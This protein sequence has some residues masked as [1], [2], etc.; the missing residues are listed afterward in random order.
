MKAY[1]K[2]NLSLDILKRRDDGYHEILM[3]MQSVELHD[4]LTIKLQNQGIKL[5]TNLSY[6]PSN[7]KNIVHKVAKA[8]IDKY[9]INSG[10]YIDI[11]KRIPVSAGLGGGSAD[12]AATLIG[13]NKIFDKG[14]T[15]EEL[16]SF[17]GLFGAD[18]PFCVLGGTA[19]AEGI[20]ERLTKLPS[21][22]DITILICKPKYHISTEYVYKHFDF[23]KAKNHPNTNLMIESIKNNDI[24]TLA[25]NMI[26]VMETVTTNKYPIINDIKNI[27]IQNK[28]FGSAMSGSGTSVI[29]IFSNQYEA[30]IAARSLKKVSTE[31]F[32]TNTIDFD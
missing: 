32:V 16:M 14:L 13:L 29:G 19:L 24:N 8:F 20:G 17:G 28:A 30:H 10:V 25:K 11:F 6:V 12:A 23:E 15:K 18:I 31:V 26:N 1:A 2:V 22:R 9:K 4:T 21:L 27:M 5:T 7:E 3:I